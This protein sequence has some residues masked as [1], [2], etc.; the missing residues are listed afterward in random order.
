MEAAALTSRGIDGKFFA[1][2]TDGQTLEGTFWEVVVESEVCHTH[3]LYRSAARASSQVSL[4][5][6]IHSFMQKW[7]YMKMICPLQG[8][9]VFF[10]GFLSSSN[11][12]QF[13]SPAAM[14]APPLLRD[15][16]PQSS[17]RSVLF[18]KNKPKKTSHP[19]KLQI[20]FHTRSCNRVRL[21]V[22]VWSDHVINSK[23]ISW[24]LLS[25]WWFRATG[26][27]DSVWNP[28]LSHVLVQWK[29]LPF[30]VQ[31]TPPPRNHENSKVVPVAV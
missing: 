2:Q 24:V 30:P 12:H 21:C 17:E 10:C 13:A 16:T 29:A 6:F 3:I 4:R 1:A 31:P 5:S 23:R 20:A 22:W 27:N 25:W 28:F 19:P 26:V 18:K 8:F 7:L 9:H 14:R 11:L 15:S